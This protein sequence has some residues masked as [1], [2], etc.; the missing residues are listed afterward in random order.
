[1]VS[2]STIDGDFVNFFDNRGEA[3]MYAVE[4]GLARGFRI[5]EL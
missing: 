4:H 2:L 1:M 5:E 3:L